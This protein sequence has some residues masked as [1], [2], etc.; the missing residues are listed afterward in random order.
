M[1]RAREG[2]EEASEGRRIER[3]DDRE[4]K[5]DAFLMGGESRDG[6][7]MEGSGGGV[8]PLGALWPKARQ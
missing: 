8:N 4:E 6:R 7:G 5:K 2:K 1:R 3:C